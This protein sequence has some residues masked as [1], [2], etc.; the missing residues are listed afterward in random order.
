MKRKLPTILILQVM[1]LVGAM[2]W[3][4]LSYYTD[5]QTGFI[6]RGTVWMRFSILLLPI[7]MSILGFRTVGPKAISVLRVRNKGLALLFALVGLAGLAY[8]VIVILTSFVP[9]APYSVIMGGLFVWY[10]IWMTLVALQLLVQF[11]PSPTNSAIW[12]VVAALPFCAITVYRIMIEPSSLHRIGPVVKAFSALC[13]MLWFGMLLRAL[14]IALPRQR[15]RWMYFFGVLTFLFST[16]LELPLAVHTYMNRGLP[17]LQLMEAATLAL[18]G[19]VAGS[20]SVSIAGKSEA[21]RL[22][23]KETR[24]A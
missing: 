18:L 8:G 22:E 15:V 10:G 9:F 20:V 2:Y 6:I 14:Y 21:P 3:V 13:A 1:A 19:L 23:M 17:T 4:D 5:P 24:F 11:A 7:V 16:C 12:G